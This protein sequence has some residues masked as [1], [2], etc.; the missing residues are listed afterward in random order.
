MSLSPRQQTMSCL[1]AGDGSAFAPL[2][3]RLL[4]TFRKIKQEIGRR[5]KGVVHAR[6]SKLSLLTWEED[7]EV[8]V[9]K[10]FPWLPWE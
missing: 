7:A 10:Y 4:G 1:T 6:M 5:K 8:R 2:Q 9:F 3:R